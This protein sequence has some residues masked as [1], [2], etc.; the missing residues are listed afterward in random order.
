MRGKASK[1]IHMESQISTSSARRAKTPFGSSNTEADSFSGNIVNGTGTTAISK[2]G[3]GVWT[4]AG[5]WRD[6]GNDAPDLPFVLNMPCKSNCFAL[7][8]S[9]RFAV[10]R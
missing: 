1:A 10:S 4:L 2:V 7:F 5:K 9:L 6:P 3:G 8:G